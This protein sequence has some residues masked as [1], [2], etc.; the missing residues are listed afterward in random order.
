M[1]RGVAVSK[2]L[3]QGEVRQRQAGQR[4]L[5]VVA[6]VDADGAVEEINPVTAQ[7][8]APGQERGR[9]MAKDAGLAIVA[10]VETFVAGPEQSVR[11][12]L[13]RMFPIFQT[14]VNVKRVIVFVIE[15]QLPHEF[16]LIVGD[17]F[18]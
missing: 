16:D 13:A 8:A 4:R 10:F 11:R 7:P 12:T 18:D 1:G 9:R 14:G 6:G 3:I 17:L 15:R 5:K 2:N